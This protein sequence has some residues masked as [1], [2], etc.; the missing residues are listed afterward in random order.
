MTGEEVHH[1]GVHLQ[2]VVMSYNDPHGIPGRFLET[3]GNAM[4]VGMDIVDGKMIVLIAG[5]DL[6]AGETIV[7]TDTTD[8]IR[9][10]DN[11]RDRR[12]L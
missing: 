3:G 10:A 2:P 11:H 4:T 9:G 7:P 12:R 6:M 1:G 5:M 8:P